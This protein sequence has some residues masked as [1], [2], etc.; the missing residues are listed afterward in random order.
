MEMHELDKKITRALLYKSYEIQPSEE[1]FT[2]ILAGLEKK[3]AHRTFNTSSKHY[4]IALICALS[5]IFGTTLILS[6]EVKS[7]T[8]ELINTVNTVIIWDKSNKVLEKNVDA[9]INTQLANAAT[10]RRV[11]VSIFLLQTLAGCFL[12]NQVNDLEL[13]LRFMI[14]GRV[15]LVQAWYDNKFWHRYVPSY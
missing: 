10:S 11:G 4:I 7:S 6:V 3:Q 5:V 12:L 2:L 1:T 13:Y 9:V 15:T 14:I 8:I